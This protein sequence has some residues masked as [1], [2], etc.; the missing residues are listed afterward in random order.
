MV[1]SDAS[2]LAS[3]V[4]AQ[5]PHAAFKLES[6]DLGKPLLSW[7]DFYSTL[8]SFA[9]SQS[10]TVAF[11]LATENTTVQLTALADKEI[12]EIKASFSTKIEKHQRKVATAD[13]AHSQVCTEHA[14]QLD[15][16]SRR[17]ETAHS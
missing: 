8:I 16:T 1:A 10:G 5:Y 13:L 15:R 6:L 12:D 14:P 7:Q 11:K 9:Y 17:H 3:R 2:W 4:S